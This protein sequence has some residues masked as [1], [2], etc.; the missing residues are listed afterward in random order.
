MVLRPQP[1][2]RGKVDDGFLTK[3]AAQIEPTPGGS[4]DVALC[5]RGVA[6]RGRRRS[7]LDNS[8]RCPQHTIGS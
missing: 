5:P 8:S 6:G 3:G 7:L 1:C 4:S 2:R